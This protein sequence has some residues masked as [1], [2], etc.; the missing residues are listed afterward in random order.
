MSNTEVYIVSSA[1]TA[2]GGFGG[3]LASVP[4]ASLG[5][6]AIQ[7]ALERAGLKGD[8][9]Q[10]VSMG[11]VLSAGQGQA[12]ARQA[13][14]GA[15][16]PE[17][18]PC[19]TVNKVCG[20]GLQA[21]ILMAR[22]LGLGEIDIAVAGGMENMS[23]CPYAL[24][25]ARNGYRLGHGEVVD[26]MVRDGLW[27]VYDDIH[28][29]MCA[30]R[31][32]KAQDISREMQDDIAVASY[33]R[34]VAAIADGRAKPEI[35]PVAVPSRKG[36]PVIFDEDEGPKIF[37]EAKMRKMGPAFNR[38]DGTITAGNA[39]SI[40]DGA[41]AVVLANPAGLEAHRLTPAARI[42]SWGVG[43]MAPGK[44]PLAPT[45]AIE[46]ALRAAGMTADDIDFWEINEAFAIVP[47]LAMRA[48]DIPHE[49]VNT[50][51][52]AI[53]IGH[54]IGA[55][56]ARILVT[57]LNVLR[58]EKAR[59]GLATLCIGGGEGIAMIVERLDG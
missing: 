11:C 19:T 37:D 2:V 59:Y 8:A 24:P 26:L 45:I 39:S 53:S 41:A 58:L 50:L 4:S 28:M 36:P 33:E 35:A 15:G 7:A 22:P 49:R 47:I 29:G 44:F 12:P 32:A 27:D 38:K 23:A 25:K 48:F 31:L 54:P 13:S 21:A 9:V 56:G 5:S 40:N 34:A 18:V 14:L 42:V 20:S 30:D 57:L 1:R 43:A 55:S 16:V 6:V 17:S 51:G 3:S 46:R 52:G 10:E